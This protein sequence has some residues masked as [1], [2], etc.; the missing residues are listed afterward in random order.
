MRE[1]S[2]YMQ[3][4][5]IG[6]PA[7]LAV[8][9]INGWLLGLGRT[10]EALA[11]QIVMNVANIGARHLVRLGHWIWAPMASALAPP[12]RKGSRWCWAC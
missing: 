8:Y 5:F 10:R 7:A 12:A 9:A 1:A 3:G 6:A 2:G 4:R 11:L